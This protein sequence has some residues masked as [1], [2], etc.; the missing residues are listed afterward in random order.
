MPTVGDASATVEPS[1][2]HAAVTPADVTPFHVLDVVCFTLEI[3]RHGFALPVFVRT[4]VGVL[5]P[6]PHRT[7]GQVI[8]AWLCIFPIDADR[9]ISSTPALPGYA[10]LTGLSELPRV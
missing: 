4:I 6:P 3:R 5:L 10:G 2:S 9:T 1:V 8:S 7:A